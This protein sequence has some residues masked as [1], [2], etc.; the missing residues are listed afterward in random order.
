MDIV[1]IKLRLS[2]FP[3]RP[4]FLDVALTVEEI[5]S[6]DKTKI[7]DMRGVGHHGA[8]FTRYE[9]GDIDQIE[10][11]TALVKESYERTK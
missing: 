3:F 11:A 5:T 1:L 10:E 7:R 6:V 4:N 9:L 2:E 8:G